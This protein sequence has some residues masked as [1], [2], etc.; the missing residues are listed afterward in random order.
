MSAIGKSRAEYMR[1]RR[2][3]KKNFSVLIDKSK[4]EQ[5]EQKLLARNQTKAA[6]LEEKIEEELKK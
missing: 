3:N 4:A 1:A 5:L 2:E 6:W